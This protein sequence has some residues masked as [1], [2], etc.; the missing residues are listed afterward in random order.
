M[1]ILKFGR[2]TAMSF[3]FGLT[4]A[5]SMP[6]SEIDHIGDVWSSKKL[7]QAISGSLIEESIGCCVDNLDLDC[8][9]E[10]FH[11]PKVCEKDTSDVES[12]VVGATASN[13]VKSRRSDRSQA[14]KCCRRAAY[15]TPAP[16]PMPQYQRPM[17]MHAP[18]PAYPQQ[19]AYA[20]P[21]YAPAAYAAPAYAAPAYAPPV[22]AAPAAPAYPALTAYAPPAY[23][24]PA[25]ALAPVP[26]TYVAAPPAPPTPAEPVGDVI[27]TNLEEGGIRYS[28]NG[29]QYDMNSGY[30]QK[31]AS[32]SSWTIEFDR[33]GSFGGARYTLS[34]GSYQF[35]VSERGWD[36]QKQGDTPR[37]PTPVL[38]YQNLS[39]N[40]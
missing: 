13:V 12:A 14:S 28:V 21:A 33:G 5:S 27:L 8:E 16:A 38:N 36:L 29:T 15:A 18:R 20:P 40:R 19:P 24:A 31:L 3:A 23:T 37:A 34:P 4:A 9:V 25:P 17:P 10:L 2:S 32:R 26:A 11:L 7:G 30:N 6:A 1:R 35:T 22:Y 39:F